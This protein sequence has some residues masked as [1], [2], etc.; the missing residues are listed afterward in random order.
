MD[1]VK[2]KSRLKR[3]NNDRILNRIIT[4]NDTLK[5]LSFNFFHIKKKHRKMKVQL[6]LS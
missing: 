5:S 1:L 2:Q 3:L 6:L 4:I